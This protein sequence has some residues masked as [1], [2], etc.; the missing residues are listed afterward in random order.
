MKSYFIETS[1]IVDYLK[2]KERAVFLIDSLP[3]NLVSS[4]ICL[5]ELYEGLYTIHNRK[6]QEEA[7][8]VFFSSL[9]KIYGVDSDTAKKFG[10]LR[11]NLK[12]N[13]NIIEDFDLLIA[14]TCISTGAILVTYNRKH[15]ER[16]TELEIFPDRNN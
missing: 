10:E 15:F 3:G 8:Q 9:T 13:G 2:G 11:A 4:T 16:I 7:V 12:K 6:E 5:A 14:A 1:V